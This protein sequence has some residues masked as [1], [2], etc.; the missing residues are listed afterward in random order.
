MNGTA[1]K[2]AILAGEKVDGAEVIENKN[3]Q[4]R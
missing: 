3:L 4:I 2:A 1:I